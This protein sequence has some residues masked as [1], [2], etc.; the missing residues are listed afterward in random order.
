[1]TDEPGT[2]DGGF[3]MWAMRQYW[4]LQQSQSLIS[5][6]FWVTTLTLLIYP[7]V[8]WRFLWTWNGIPGTYIGLALIGTI[9]VI[10]VFSIGFLYD[11]FFALW[12]EHRTI[13][14]ERDPFATHLLTPFNAMML[15]QMVTLMRNQYP[16]DEAIQHQCDWFESWIVTT[17]DLEVFRRTVKELD[18]R[19]PIPVPEMSFFPEGVVE[20]ARQATIDL[21]NNS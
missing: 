11:Q 5:M 18:A 13:T 15:G 1:M 8:E 17:T 19:L 10:V 4:R 9:V 16:D 3:K 14:L 6:V 2:N 21:E 20:A 7:L 12:K